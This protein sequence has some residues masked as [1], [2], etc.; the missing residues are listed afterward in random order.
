M[1]TAILART[2][3]GIPSLLGGALPLLNPVGGLTSPFLLNSYRSG[4][5]KVLAPLSPR[6][7]GSLWKPPLSIPSPVTLQPTFMP[8]I[9]PSSQGPILEPVI[10]FLNSS[11]PLSPP[12][13]G[14][15]A[16]FLSPT[17]GLGR[18]QIFL[19]GG[20]KSRT[21]ISTSPL[22][23]I[24]TGRE[25][26]R[27]AKKP[28]VRLLRVAD[29]RMYLE[30]FEQLGE[31]PSQLIKALLVPRLVPEGGLAVGMGV[32]SYDRQESQVVVDT[33]DKV[34][35]R[36]ASRFD[37]DHLAGKPV[38]V[39]IRSWPE[40][41]AY[42]LSRFIYRITVRSPIGKTDPTPSLKERLV[43]VLGEGPSFIIADRQGQFSVSLSLPGDLPVTAEVQGGE[44]VMKGVVIMFPES[45]IYYLHV[46]ELPPSWKK[47]IPEEVY[48]IVEGLIKIV[49]KDFV[50]NPAPGRG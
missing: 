15:E 33:Y 20:L 48:E 29:E 43:R 34:L 26:V 36:L 18:G 13:I 27:E 41:M 6:L 12:P 30:P 49:G 17:M 32:V 23:R 39:Q 46:R 1:H 21:P 4:V 45:L 2:V 35:G 3:A 28:G 42:V 44:D 24:T 38:E 9:P 37:A 50:L 19:S 10:S 31:E 7:A 8:V 16:S 25:L 47:K 5:E 40:D 22:T 11:P 14:P